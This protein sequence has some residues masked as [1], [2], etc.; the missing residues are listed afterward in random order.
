MSKR[1]LV[2][3]MAATVLTAAGASAGGIVI[4]HG[5]RGEEKTAFEKVVALFNE[6]MASRGIRATTLAVPYDAFADKI[7][8]SVPRGKGPDIFIFAQDRLGGWVEAGNTIEQIDFFLD[9]A[10]TSRFIPTTMEAMVY[11]GTT[12]GLPFNYKC[13]S[14]I[15]NTKLVEK[16]PATSGELVAL[17]R[18]LTDASSGR[19]GLAYTYSDFYFHASLMNAFGGGVFDK[20]R[21]PTVNAPANIKSIELLMKWYQQDKFLPAEPSAALITQLFNSGKAAIVFNGPWFLGEIS[22]DISFAI[23]PLP[24]IDEAGGQPMR[25][26][27]TVEG[28]YIAA[29]SKNKDDAYEFLK[30]ATDLQAARVMALE[31]R[32][33]PANAAVYADPKV[34]ADPILAAF[35]RQVDVAIP[36]PNF[37]EMAMFWSPVTTAMNAITKGGAPKAE[38]DRAQREVEQRISSLRKSP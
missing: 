37:A 22:K 26:W 20:A 30:F 32:Q 28:M 14:M 15:Y 12:Y 23:A 38:L 34:A 16:P 35:K 5:Y 4:W 3:A 21:K 8:A 17:A 29:A 11:K 24:T 33:T 36:M 19:F 25:P 13:I 7:T 1:V 31:G 2:L 18:K 9:K 6:A 27:M 10:V